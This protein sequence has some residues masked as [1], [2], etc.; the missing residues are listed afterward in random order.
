MLWTPGQQ[1]CGGIADGPHDVAASEDQIHGGNR[2]PLSGVRGSC[3]DG[4]WTQL[5]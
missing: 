2:S 1:S 3:F 5:E 4:E